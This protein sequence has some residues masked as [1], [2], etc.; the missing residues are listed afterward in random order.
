MSAPRAITLQHRLE[1][2]GFQGLMGAF[3]S[4]PLDRASAIGARLGALLG[5][6]LRAHRTALRNLALAFPERSAADRAAIAHGMW[7]QLGRTVAEFAHLD[8]IR[9]YQGDGRVEVVQAERL[10]AV[11]EDGRGA[12]FISG[13]FANWEIMAAALVQRGLTCHV[14]YRPANNPLV[15]AAINAKRRAYGVE[16]QSAKG[17]QGGLGLLR[18]LARGET[19]A[20]MND[21]KYAEGVS[22]PLFGHPTPTADGAVRLALRFGAPLIPLSVRRLEG[23]RFQV[24]VHA[25][26]ALLRE[27]PAEEAVRAAVLEIN[28]FVEA[29]VREA[30]EQWF[31]VHRRW[32][33]QTWAEAGLLT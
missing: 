30:P 21:Q 10:D 15:D 12:V 2:L 6:R 9:P 17:R 8:A 5:P 22:A 23:A 11:R 26:L 33:K 24:Q 29:R 27:A 3:R 7:A 28:A 25:P 18:A 13:H 14:T 31:W 20:L 16:L 1:H 4:Q 19:V 32:P